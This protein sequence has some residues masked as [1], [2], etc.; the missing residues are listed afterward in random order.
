[1]SWLRHWRRAL[2]R[3][4]FVAIA[5]TATPAGACPALTVGELADRLPGS[6]RYDFAGPAIAPF[7]DLWAEGGGRS[8]PAMPDGVALFVRPD[9]PLLV[10]FRRTGCLVALLPSRP[11]DLWR[12]MRR[13]F[14]E[15]A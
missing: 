5:F 13:R 11:A 4:L 6:Q 1:M 9:R 12:A 3:G 15:I 2:P 7:L 8:L 10:A 14:G